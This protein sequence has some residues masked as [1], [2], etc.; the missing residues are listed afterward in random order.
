MELITIVIILAVIVLLGLMASG[1]VKAPPDK[2][3]IISG[4]KKNP[5]ILIGRAGVKFPFLE[6]KDTLVLK[7]I[8]IDIKTNGY[9]PTLDFIGVDIDAVAKVRVKTD[10]EG[11]K[12][13]MKNFLNM[14]EPTIIRALTDSLQGNMRE[15]IGTVKLK[16]LNTDRKKF[17]DEVQEKAQKDM[18][19]LG[20]EI[21]SC[22]IQKIEDEKGLIIALGQD[23]MSQIQ[24]DASIAKA[25]ADKDV[26]IAEAEAKRLAN[27]AQVAAETE[28][29]AKQNELRIKQAEL[30]KESDTRQ[31]EADAAY[32]IQQQ[33]QR[34]T[35]EI[36]TAN[37]NIAR[38]EREIE[39]RKKDVEV[40]EQTLEAEIKK[41]A[42][43][44]KFARQQKAEA[45]LFERQRKAEAE[46][47]E[48]EKEAEAKKIQA[49][50]DLFSK[51]KEAE[52]IRMVGEAEAKAIEAK[53]IA[54]AEA[55]EKKAEAMK[56]YGQAAM[57]EM[58]VK[59]LPDMAGAIA[60]PLENI[61][62]V[63]IIDG[64]NGEN[65]VNSVG[66]YVPGVL[67]KTMETVK[68]VTGLD[69]VDIMKANTYDAKVTRNVNVTGLD[70]DS[71]KAV[72]AA[73]VTEA[74]KEDK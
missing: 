15:I 2:A 35:I 52:G 1:Y 48:R 50:A 32:E 26:A 67:A 10:P 18:N 45:D 7:Q 40:T 57:I 28:I 13:A 66:S 11:I 58:I 59:A 33:E 74:A 43:A 72:K 19:A 69:I 54:E 53:G 64:G 73:V 65:G 6:R 3:Y 60:K 61:D 24:K 56:K 39:L 44:E 31:A 63:T 37:A 20:I 71:K 46:K 41:K 36:T 14:D 4:M 27:E 68:E 42:E 8:S 55:M 9:V 70:E 29:A 34:K 23:N 30:K 22:N 38:Q 17:G 62:K 47:F 12:V 5:K 25:Q 21:I 16:E 49:E 51:E